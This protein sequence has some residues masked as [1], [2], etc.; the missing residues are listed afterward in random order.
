MTVTEQS[1]SPVRAIVH[2]PASREVADQL[3]V[4]VGSND[5]V[6]IAALTGDL[7]AATVKVLTTLIGGL[8]ESGQVQVMLD[9]RQLYTVDVDGLAGLHAARAALER[10]GGSLSMTGVRP[11]VRAVLGRDGSAAKFGVSMM[12]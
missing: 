7:T 8:A 9:C 6:V 1:A 10:V 4:Q 11:Q 5:D 3:D 12:P 2:Q